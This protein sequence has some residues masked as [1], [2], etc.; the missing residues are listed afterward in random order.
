M[1][2]FILLIGKTFLHFYN[3]SLLLMLSVCVSVDVRLDWQLFNVESDDQQLV[4]FVVSYG[5]AFPKKDAK[6]NVITEISTT[7]GIN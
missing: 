5:D 4:D 7:P 6:G 2:W 3:N 1:L